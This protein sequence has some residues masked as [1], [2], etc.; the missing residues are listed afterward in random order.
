MF[1]PYQCLFYMGQYWKIYTVRNNQ[2]KMTF[3]ILQ[4]LEKSKGQQA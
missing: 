4:K 1:L 2:I 3:R